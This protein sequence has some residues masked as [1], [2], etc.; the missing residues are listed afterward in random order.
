MTLNLELPE[1]RFTEYEKSRIIGS[2]ALQLSQGAPMR[3]DL[4]DDELRELDYNP[5]EI[6]K[7]EFEE[8]ELNI[9]VNRERQLPKHR[10]V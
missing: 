2:R 5:I 4:D 1:D 6:A 7:R 3:V 10:K 9:T 8:D